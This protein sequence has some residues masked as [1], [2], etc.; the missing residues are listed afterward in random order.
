MQGLDLV[1]LI[2]TAFLLIKGIW[3]GFVKEVA[4]IIAVML[5]VF[6]SFRFH[7]DT[8]G[9]L[10]SFID[11][12]YATVTAYLVL[13]LAVY[14]AVMLFGNLLDKVLKSVFL[15]GV[16]R[17]FGGVF[18]LLKSVLWLTLITFAYS[19]IK[20]GAGL[21]HPAWIIDS[22]FYP[23]LLDFTEIMSSFLA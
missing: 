23:F 7:K 9:Y 4:G 14:L 3:K 5:A 8:A 12:K 22:L 10:V 18:G 19:T 17:L 16:N 2:F 6:I 1:I 21:H 20:D 11:E 13:F 15:G